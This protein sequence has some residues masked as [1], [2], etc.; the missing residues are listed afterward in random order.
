MGVSLAQVANRATDGKAVVERRRQVIEAVERAATGPDIEMEP[1]VA[2]DL[3][4]EVRNNDRELCD[5]EAHTAKSRQ[6][7]PDLAAVPTR[8]ERQRVA[9]EMAERDTILCSGL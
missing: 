5:R 4:D 6:P 3:R 2:V 7:Q 9:L 1:V 8:R